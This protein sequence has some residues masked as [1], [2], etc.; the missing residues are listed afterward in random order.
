MEGHRIRFVYLFR[1]ISNQKSD[2]QKNVQSNENHVYD[3]RNVYKRIHVYDFN[4]MENEWEM[5]KITVSAT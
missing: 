5:E 2:Q 3:Q 4:D 1:Y